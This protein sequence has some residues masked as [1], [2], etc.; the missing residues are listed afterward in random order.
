MALAMAFWA[1]NEALYPYF[2]KL[3]IN[4]VESLSPGQSHPFQALSVPLL[5]L[6][7]SWVMMEISMRSLGIVSLYAWPEFR[8]NIREAIFTYTQG[9]SHNYFA[10][11]FAGSIANKISELPRA[12]ERIVDVFIMSFFATALTFCISLVVIF[13]VSIVF[14]MTLIVWVLL[15]IGITGLYLHKINSTSEVHAESVATLSGQIVDSLSNM[16]TARLFS[17]NK[18]ELKYLGKYQQDEI[19]KSYKSIWAIEELNIFR[20]ILSVI[21]MVVMFLALI[22]GWN[23]QRVSLGDFSLISMTSFNLMGLIWHCAYNITEVVKEIG[24]AQAALSLLNIPHGIQNS[25]QAKAL[26]IKKGEIKFENVTFQYKRNSNVFEN[27]TVKIEAGQKVGLV[28]FSGSGKS[29]FANLI[30]RFYDIHEGRILI[31]D[32]NISEVTQE[33]LR[34][35]IAMIPQEPTL[36]HRTLLDN[37]RYGRLEATDEEVFE[38]ARRAHCDEFIAQLEEG[39]MSMVGERGLKLSGGQ[40][41]RIAIARAIL[42]NAPILILDEATSALDSVTEK[43]IQD[44]LKELMKDRT[45]LVIAHRLSTLQDMDR[46]LVFHR[47]EIIE[48][49]TVKAL[50]KKKGHFAHLWQ[51]Q[52][53][54]F[55]PET[56]E[57]ETT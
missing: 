50:L 45:S 27:K 33:S 17:Q 43:M 49:G 34:A 10:N 46:I 5:Y 57:P 47:G 14:G 26:E 53:G 15:F 1:I 28:G 32:Q 38:A 25:P 30:L 36:F 6:L 4:E 8:K 11:N 16:M 19:N 39:Y 9:H 35:Q 51:M 2:T 13:Q 41:Q 48:D 55:L 56:A 24:S 40:R 52:S 18:Y 3:L 20:G 7:I 12:C 31:D 42:K 37:I 54:G 29:T 44:S 21:F 22:Y 23:Q